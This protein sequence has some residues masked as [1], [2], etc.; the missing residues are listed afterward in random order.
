MPEAQLDRFLL[1]M[2]ITYP[3]T[4]QE[5]RVIKTHQNPLKPVEQVLNSVDVIAIQKAVEGVHI[6]DELIR[7]IVD[8]ARYTREHEHSAL[9]ASPRA[10]LALLRAAKARALIRERDFVL[11]DDVRALAPGVLTHRV[12]LVPQA[13]LS[14]LS[15][16]RIVA[17]ALARVSYARDARGK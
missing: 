6:S 10:A 1:K 16:E 12:L 11:P 7:Y 17:E 13:Q 4:E 8:L 5:F 15:A 14:G 9:G 2:V 3:T